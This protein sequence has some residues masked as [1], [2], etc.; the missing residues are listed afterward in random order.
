MVGGPGKLTYLAPF[1]WL[2]KGYVALDVSTIRSR[3]ELRLEGDKTSIGRQARRH[4]PCRWHPMQPYGEAE[5]PKPTI[6]GLR[7]GGVVSAMLA[8]VA[9]FIP[10]RS[11]LGSAGMSLLIRYRSFGMIRSIGFGTPARSSN[12]RQNALTDHV[13]AHAVCVGTFLLCI[14]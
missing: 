8:Q 9:V 6:F 3:T 4:A 10:S 14:D 13:T 2:R 12:C 1:H 5:A 7:G 11:C